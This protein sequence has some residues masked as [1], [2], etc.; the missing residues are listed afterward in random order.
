MNFYNND[1]VA[2]LEVVRSGSVTR[3]ATEL[4]LT[5][6]AVSK[7]VR[8]LEQ[9]VGVPLLE[10][11]SKGA[12]LTGEGKVFLENA[13]RFDAQHFELVRVASDLRARHA[14][15]LRLGVTSPAADGSAVR[16]VAEMVRRRPAMR[17]QLR[18][19]RSDALDR[20][21]SV[22]E[23]DLAV[24]P[25]YPGQA[26]RCASAEI[27]EDH[28]HVVVR[29][30]HPL[31]GR[32]DVALQDLASY[33]WVLPSPDSAAR[34]HVFE[35]YERGRVPRPHVNVEAE[36][37]SEAALGIVLNTDLVTIVPASI[38]RSWLGR[39]QP[40]AVAGFGIQR[41]QVLLSHAQA[42]WTPLM[43][44]FREILLAMRRGDEK[45]PMG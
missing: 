11:A 42:R 19:G 40:L 24:V 25:S 32:S 29:S 31:L 20:Q 6:P 1:V 10:R 44:G 22:G 7:A 39:V 23:L 16:A 18:I 15:L 35:L 5:Q 28:M 2:F 9:S 30:G 13:Q 3:A 27:G 26:L 12:R 17:L 45:T 21:V 34:R 41:K 14:G 33:G 8:R 36:Y 37:T 38:L 4:G 43:E